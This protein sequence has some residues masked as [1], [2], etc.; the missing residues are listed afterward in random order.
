MLVVL[1]AAQLMAM[2]FIGGDE[3]PSS[4][5]RA[6]VEG[7]GREN[8]TP[9]VGE[10]PSPAA[11]SSTGAVDYSLRLGPPPPRVEKRLLGITADRY[12]E[13]LNIASIWVVWGFLGQL[14]FDSPRRKAVWL[15]MPAIAPAWVILSRMGRIRS[16]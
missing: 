14:C 13:L 9:I 10:L 1:T 12:E 7:L 11:T 5:A 6:A 8:V 2:R 4:L 16:R 3:W 15:L